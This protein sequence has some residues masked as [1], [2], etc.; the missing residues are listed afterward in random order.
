MS[1]AS[2]RERLERALE[3]KGHKGKLDSKIV[4]VIS[5][6][7]GVSIARCRQIEEKVMVEE[8][9]KRC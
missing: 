4:E 9:M 7:T 6:S 2:E 3:N 5:R 8:A 1:E